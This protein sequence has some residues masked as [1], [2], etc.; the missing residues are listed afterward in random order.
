MVDLAV[1]CCVFGMF[2]RVPWIF[3][4]YLNSTLFFLVS[5]KYSVFVDILCN[6]VLTFYVNDTSH[7][8]PMH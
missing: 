5:V 8:I 1:I 3:L 7:T 6:S 2:S 4:Y